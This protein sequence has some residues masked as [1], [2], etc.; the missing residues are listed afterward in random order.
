MKSAKW[1]VMFAALFAVALPGVNVASADDAAAGPTPFPQK[2]QD[3]PGK[4]VIRK[5]DFMVGERNAFW[6][7]RNSDQGA[8]VFVGDSLTG[9][10]KN[11]ARDFPKLKVANRGLGGDVSRGVLFRFKE[12]VLDLNPKALVICIGNNDLTAMG[13]PAD[14]LSNLAD[15][16]ALADKERPGMPVVL[17]TIPPSANPKAPI[18]AGDR[19]AM[20]QGIRKIASERKNTYFCDLF[21]ATAN[22]DGSP[23][24]ECFAPDKLHL[25]SPG[26]AK[27]IELLTPIFEKLNLK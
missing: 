20:N 2:D 22:E 18:K 16:L 9:G 23:K 26:Y 24:L 13:K 17:C 1:L 8:V 19:T 7:Q 12:D 25:A 4:G 27:W 10:W 15:T 5:F 3:W 14:M 11:L 6:K 21:A